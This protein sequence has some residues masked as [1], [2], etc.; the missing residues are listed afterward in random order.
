MKQVSAILLDFV[1]VAVAVAV[2]IPACVS[3]TTT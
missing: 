3:H 2:E 1:V